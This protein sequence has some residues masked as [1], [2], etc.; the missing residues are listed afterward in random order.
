M[1]DLFRQHV[2][3]AG[4]RFAS[5]LNAPD[6]LLNDAGELVNS[7][8]EAQRADLCPL[9]PIMFMPSTDPDVVM[10]QKEVSTLV[11]YSY[12]QVHCIL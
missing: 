3:G 10:L 2:S 9:A 8:E 12:V 5:I 7:F 4:Q 11:F 6:K 1:K